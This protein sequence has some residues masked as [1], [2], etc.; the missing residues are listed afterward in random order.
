MRARLFIFSFSVLASVFLIGEFYKKAAGKNRVNEFNR[1]RFEEFYETPG[2]ELF[3]LGSSHSY[4]TFDPEVFE[5]ELGLRSYQLGLPSQRPDATYY[6]AREIV[7]YFAP[8]IFVMEI[9]WDML[10]EDFDV[11]QADALFEVMRS[12]SLKREFIRDAF[13]F[14]E[15]IK[16]NINAARYMADFFT[17]VNNL[18]KSKIDYKETP[19]AE[20]TATVTEGTEY[21]RSK[22]Y[23]FCDYIINDDELDKTNQ[24]KNFDGENFKISKRQQSYL[25]KLTELCESR[26]IKLFF[27]TAPIAPVSMD[28][29]KNYEK[30]N[31]AVSAAARELNVEYL[32][33]NYE[34]KN[35]LRLKDFRDDAH[36]N[37]GG[38]K[39]VSAFY[40]EYLKRF[41]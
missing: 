4:C 2:L 12:E 14:N 34:T 23:V 41:L 36:L 1:Q 16:Y 32:D 38:V 37:D 9:Y 27:V 30:I 28:Y 21:Y 11:K 40:A 10:D 25:K 7:N 5:N 17:Y 20:E 13:P 22:G 6:T 18:L 35:L 33:L 26:N 24:F 3:F 19:P 15:K 31:A 39:I 8:K 29:I